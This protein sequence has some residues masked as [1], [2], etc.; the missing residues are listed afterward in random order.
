MKRFTETTKWNDPWF[1]RLSPY[2]KTFWEY[3]R[4]NC[5]NAGVWKVDLELASFH[6]GCIFEEKDILG[7]FEGRI[8]DIGNGRWWVQK[9]IAFQYGE[10]SESSKPHKHVLSLMRQHRIPEGYPEG[11]HTLKDTDK[12]KEKDKE[13]DR[14]E[15]EGRRPKPKDQAQ[16]VAYCLSLGLL[17]SDGNYFWNKW[18]GNGFKNAGSA[19]RDWQAVIRSWR[20]AGHLPSQKGNGQL[21]LAAK[22]QEGTSLRQD[23]LDRIP[24]ETV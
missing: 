24:T 3:I 7:A 18:T 4:D 8:R 2:H 19:M 23:Q 20:D 16:V 5:D 1:R 21:R 13:K 6:C 9:F 14:G 17:E 12:D 10:L 15:S 11:I 22:R